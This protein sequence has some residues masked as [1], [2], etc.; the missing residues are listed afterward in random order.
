VEVA[1]PTRPPGAP[2]RGGRPGRELREH[3]APEKHEG[4]PSARSGFRVGC[5][6]CKEPGAILS[7]VQNALTSCRIAA[8]EIA[9]WSLECKYPRLRFEVNI[10]HLDDMQS[11][12]V[13]RFRRQQGEERLYRQ[14]VDQLLERVHL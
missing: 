8:R 6:S 2:R 7:S 9:P 1:A 13:V 14:V 5:T 11:M 12:Y 4:P 3:A 10:A